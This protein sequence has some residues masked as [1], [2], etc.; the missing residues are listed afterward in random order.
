MANII[1]AIINM[2]NN[3]VEK[4]TS[5]YL[6]KNKINNVGDA[7]EEYVKDLFADSFD[8]SDYDRNI[9]ISQTFSYLGNSSNPPDGM[10][11]DG[12]AYEVKKIS[13]PN[14]QLALNSSKPKQKLSVDCPLINNACKD[15]EGGTWREKDFIYIVGNIDSQNNIRHLCMVYGDDYCANDETYNKIARSIKQSV[16]NTIGFESQSTKELG[17]F[18]RVDPLGISY[19]RVRGMWGIENPWQVFKYIFE[20]NA[21]TEFDFMGI[22]NEDKWLALE[23]TKE[24][25]DLS[26]KVRSLNIKDV[27]INNPDNP[28]LMKKAKLVT[29]YK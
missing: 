1:N 19:L 21:N 28:A 13:S 27:M 14:S 15:A 4:I 24:L 22:I 9:K 26:L 20:R 3:P 2:I 7:L 12:D 16:D 5:T 6:G 8:L 29:Y 23:N 25:M 17:R 10:L 11:F 18:N